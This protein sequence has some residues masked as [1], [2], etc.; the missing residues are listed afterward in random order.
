MRFPKNAVYREAERIGASV[1]WEQTG[2]VFTIRIA[3][4]R[5]KHWPG[6]IHELVITARPTTALQRDELWTDAFTRMDQGL[7]TCDLND[8]GCADWVE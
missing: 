6:D 7:V 8:A 4:P 3:A 1:E 2:S 5:G